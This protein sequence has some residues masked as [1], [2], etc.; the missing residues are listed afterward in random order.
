M[1]SEADITNH[2]ESG[3]LLQRLCNELRSD[4]VDPAS[5]SIADLAPYDQFHGRG[6]EATEEI[7]AS[8]SIESSEHILDVGSGIGGPARYFANRFSCRVTGIDLTEE[9]CDV[10]RHLTGLLKLENRVAITHGNALTMP[11]SDAEFDGAY[12]MNVSMNI[13]DK[14]AFYGEIYRV[15]KPGAWLVLSEIAKGPGSDMDYPTPWATNAASSFLSTPDQ[16]REKLIENG[17]EIV[18]MRDAVEEFMDFGRRSRA[19]INSGGKP[20]QRTV[21]LIH[22]ELAAEAGRNIGRG[23]REARIIPVEI[24]CTKVS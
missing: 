7:A 6:I 9:F 20:P 22:G 8:L 23:V 16:I 13:S 3:D 1:K 2:Y 11:F 21:P 4:N 24:I 17:F 14:D 19:I 18:S 12:S 15:L 10:A 5:P